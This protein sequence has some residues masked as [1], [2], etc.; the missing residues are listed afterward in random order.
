MMDKQLMDREP[1]SKYNLSPT[2]GAI[3]LRSSFAIAFLVATGCILESP[4]QAVP[5]I[6]SKVT[7]DS[8]QLAQIGISSPSNAPI[9]LNLRPRT[10]IP[11]PTNSH[12]SDDDYYSEYDSGYDD[13]YR[14]AR[15]HD[16][17]RDCHDHRDYPSGRFCDRHR[18]D[19]VIIINPAR[20]TYGSY[21]DDD[22]DSNQRR[23]IRI[24]RNEVSF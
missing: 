14:D 6:G 12:S 4:A 24:I 3:G 21:G 23:Y 15:E 17:H 7:K 13:G 5:E 2:L 8:F 10:H 11:L 9:P 19:T 22:L 1:W 20:S 18:K 16:T